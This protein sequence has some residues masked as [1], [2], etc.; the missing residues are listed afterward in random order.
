M[1]FEYSAEQRT[2]EISGVKIG[3]EPGLAPTVMIGSMFYRGHKIVSAGQ[4][5]EFD[6]DK[7]ES[8]VNRME[9]QTEKTGLPSICSHT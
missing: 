9:E 3:G 1:L 5:G 4:A 6:E 8:I 7:A 2:Y